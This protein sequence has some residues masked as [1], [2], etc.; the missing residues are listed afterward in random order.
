MACKQY[1][2][3]NEKLAIID[4][5]KND[6]HFPFIPLASLEKVRST[7]CESVQSIF[8]VRGHRIHFKTYSKISK[9]NSYKLGRK[10]H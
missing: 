4:P 6:H 1:L 5:S 7:V 3:R 8:P 9:L 10:L 2:Y